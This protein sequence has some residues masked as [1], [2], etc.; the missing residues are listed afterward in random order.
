MKKL[1]MIAM[2]AI[3]TSV[4]ANAMAQGP[5]EGQ[6][7]E[8]PTVE[9]RVEQMKEQLELSDEQCAQ[10]MEYESNIK[11]PE[12][13]DR[14]AMKKMMEERD[15]KYKEILTEEQYTKFQKMQ[16]QRRGQQGERPARQ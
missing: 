9:Q 16:Q 14:D 5:Q 15:A 13:G 3:F 6:Q 2:A 12:R 8:Q 10:I 4:G 11:M 1:M 7:R